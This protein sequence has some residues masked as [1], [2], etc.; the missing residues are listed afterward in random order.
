[1]RQTHWLAQ[2]VKGDGKNPKPLSNVANVLIA[3]RNDI[4]L[5]DA[6]AYDEMLRATLLLHEIGVPLGGNVEEPRPLTDK[7]VTALQ[8]WI[9]KAGL[10]SISHENVHNAV[11]C[12][13][14]EHAFHPVLD[15]LDEL[16]W[17]ETPRLNGWLASYLGTKANDYNAAIGAMFLISMV[18]RIFEPGC[19]CDHMLVLEGEQGALKSA[20]CQILG[21]QYFSDALPEITAGKDVSQHL[22]GK[23]LIEV[24]EMHA[25]NRAEAALLKSFISRTTE[26]Y[27]PSYGRL[28]VIEPR[29]CVFIGTSNQDT[30][31][32][33]E[34]GNRRYWPA[35][36][37][38]INLDALT[39]DRDQLFAEA[40]ARYR[41]GEQWWPDKAFERE[42]IHC[43]QEA[44][45]EL[46]AWVDSTSRHLQTLR[47]TTIPDIAVYALGLD[48]SRLGIPEQKRIA[49]ILRK[50][51][52]RPQR[53]GHE[54]W[55]EKPLE[56]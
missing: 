49:A 29:Q 10:K 40:V 23:W 3:L 47:R 27:R 25:M 32:R 28:E 36:C 48:L 22:R 50:L 19:K 12:Y 15:Y 53:N 17:D 38:C 6:F 56:H 54:R 14:R 26:R 51:G 16:T 20:A 33:D 35:K 37:G 9:Q 7:D 21:G 44:R 31:L 13:A 2:C 43:E 30:Y 4:T 42:I 34:T 11:E 8:D 1:M 39:A 24:S 41:R 55:W 52:W 5:R 46:D 18:A 45:Y